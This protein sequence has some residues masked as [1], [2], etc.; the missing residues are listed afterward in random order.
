M[1]S[2]GAAELDGQLIEAPH[3]ARAHRTLRVALQ[4]QIAAR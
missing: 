4:A 3:L 1:T 2:L